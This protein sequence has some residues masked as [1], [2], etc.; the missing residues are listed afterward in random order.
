VN[1]WFK[2]QYRTDADAKLDESEPHRFEPPPI[3]NDSQNVAPP[4]QRDPR[5]GQFRG[6]TRPLKG[7]Y[8]FIRERFQDEIADAIARDKEKGDQ[9]RRE[10]EVEEQ[11][12]FAAGLPPQYPT[13]H[14]MGA[15]HSRVPV[16]AGIS[17]QYSHAT[18][19]MEAAHPAY[20]PHVGRFSMA[21][22]PHRDFPESSFRP[23]Y[24]GYPW[25]R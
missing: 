11:A 7:G 19:M 8:W 13:T 6:G 12:R 5:M 23:D 14:M 18:T 24:L 2:K 9:T 20:P 21:P 16:A 4:T 15:T 10:I 1:K 25:E 22:P 17:G 3:D